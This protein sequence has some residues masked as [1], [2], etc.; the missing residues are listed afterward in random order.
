LLIRFLPCCP[1]AGAGTCGQVAAGA[2][3]RFRGRDQKVR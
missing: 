2:C 1:V 3:P